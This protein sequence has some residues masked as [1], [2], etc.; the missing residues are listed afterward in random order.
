MSFVM[1]GI[2]P[3]DQQRVLTLSRCVVPG[4]RQVAQII[5][6]G[7]ALDESDMWFGDS[8]SSWMNRL[9]VNLNRMASIVNME[10]ITVIFRPLKHRKGNF[11]AAAPPTGGWGTYTTLQDARGQ[12]FTLKLDTG[13]N[14][15]VLYRTRTNLDSQFQTFVH[16]ITHMLLNTDDIAVGQKR[17]R[18]LVRESPFRAKNNADNWGYFVEECVYRSKVS[19]DLPAEDMS[20]LS[21]LF[22]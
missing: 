2:S 5:S 4:L 3:I 7:G 22:E 11:A 14:E 21:S 9:A 8:A 16:E 6:R 12:N 20:G 13:F 1:R 10:T 15:T 18:M 17:S 19:A